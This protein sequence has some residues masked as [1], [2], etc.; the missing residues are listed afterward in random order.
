MEL[1]TFGAIFKFA[2][3]FEQASV[4]YYDQAMFGDSP[5]SELAVGAKKRGERLDRVRREMVTE[6][7]LEPISGHQAANYQMDWTMNGQ[8]ALVAHARAIEETGCRFYTDMAAC[9]SVAEVAR[10]FKKLAE[11]H[12]RNL[13][14][15]AAL[16]PGDSV[17]KKSR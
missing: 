13:A 17:Q 5:F 2:I 11:E 4:T 6:M 12:A 8:V 1:G 9:V 10:V 7:I 16:E 14:V 15:L 3:D